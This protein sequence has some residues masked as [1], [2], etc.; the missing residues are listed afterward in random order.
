MASLAAQMQSTLGM[1]SATADQWDYA[2]QKIMGQPI[3]KKYGFSFDTVYGP[4]V[5]GA[6][7]TGSMS[8]MGFL[9]TAAAAVPGGLPGMSGFGTIT[10]FPGPKYSTVGTMV[11]QLMHPLPYALS[12]NLRGFRGG[13]G[14]F[15]HASGFERAL[16]AGRRL[17]R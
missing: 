4:L 5:N 2:F 11:T 17:I 13:M 7:S 9:L 3:D 10:R 12:Y 6:R 8:A 16:W 15:T 1:S 14:A